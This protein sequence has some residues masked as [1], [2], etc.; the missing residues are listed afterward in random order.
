MK[1]KLK[2]CKINDKEN[3]WFEEYD[4]NI[5]DPE[6]WGKVKQPLFF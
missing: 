2:L 5:D 3:F 6:T 1:F 4:E